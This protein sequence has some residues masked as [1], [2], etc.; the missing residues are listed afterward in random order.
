MKKVQ[1]G[2]FD[3]VHSHPETWF[4]NLCHSSRSKKCVWVHTYHTMYFEEDNPE[5]LEPYEVEMNQCLLKVASKADVRLCVSD[6][7]HDYLL[8]NHSISTEV[9]HNGVD[10]DFCDKANPA[11]FVDKYGVRN[12]V[13]FVGYLDPI[14]NPAM[15]VNLAAEMP[16]IKFVM[17]GRNLDAFQLANRFNVRIPR[18]L[19]VMRE[20]TH[21]DLIDAISACK[22]YVM[23][24][25]REG[26]PTSLLEAMGLRKPVVV[27]N[28]SGCREIVSDDD[29]GFLYRSGSFSDLVEKTKNALLS[30]EVGEKARERVEKNFDW[31]IIA[32]KLDRIYDLSKRTE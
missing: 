26:F 12:F 7:F 22:A 9:V 13:L 30:K 5:G 11:R 24:S 8:R 14:K 3:I 17:I 4:I 6:W 25:K 28:H 23:T 20:M 21:S 2:Q 29:Y 19:F 15:F 1:F 27:P 32:K 18:N 10:L 31:Q 16:E